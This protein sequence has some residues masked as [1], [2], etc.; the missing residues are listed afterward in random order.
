M[1]KNVVVSIKTVA[2]FAVFAIFLSVFVG[3]SS[4]T[5][6]I[7]TWSNENGDTLEIV[8]DGTFNSEIEVGGVSEQLTGTWNWKE[9]SDLINFICENGNVLLSSF[10][11]NGGIL[12]I[13]W[14]PDSANSEIKTFMKIK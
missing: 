8:E 10:E 3:C 13:L 9:G 7:G 4:S 11:V 6:L 12:T 14:A 1:K 5:L 2:I